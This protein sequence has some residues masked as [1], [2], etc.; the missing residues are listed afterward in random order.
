MELV[1]HAIDYSQRDVEGAVE[2]QCYKGNITITGR[3]SPKTLYSSDLASMEIEGGGSI[4]YE[5]ADA[6]GFIR[7]NS[8]RLK[9]YNTLR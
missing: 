4:D 3:E 2:L 9:A 1:K 6:Q 7:I 8:T 5:P